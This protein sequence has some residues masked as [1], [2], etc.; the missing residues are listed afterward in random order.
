MHDRNHFEDLE[1]QAEAD[2]QARIALT[3]WQLR[4][5]LGV[6]LQAEPAALRQLQPE[7]L[8]PAEVGMHELA[9]DEYTPEELVELFS[10]AHIFDWDSHK[11]VKL[12][13]LAEAC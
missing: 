8:T 6:Q 5:E 3:H 4:K 11:C 9:S 10:D 7:T 2:L 13:E 1:V 12:K